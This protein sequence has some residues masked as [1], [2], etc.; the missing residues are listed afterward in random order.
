MRVARA[1][2]GAFDARGEARAPRIA[3]VRQRPLGKANVGE[4]EGSTFCALPHVG[5]GTLTIVWV[6]ANIVFFKEISRG[7]YNTKFT[8]LVVGI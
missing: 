5:C 3:K 7:K 2:V 1:R 4:A 8:G 6:R